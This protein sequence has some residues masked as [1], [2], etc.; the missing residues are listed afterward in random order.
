MESN[1]PLN[2]LFA[3][4]SPARDD[5]QQT[6]FGYDV[7]PRYICNNWDEVNAAQGIGA[8]PFDVIVVGAGMFGGYTAEK[9]YRA[10]SGAA[11]R[12][13]LIDAGA[14]LLQSHIQNL[15][16]QLG[17]SV[18]GPSYLRTRDDASGAQNVVW[19][20]PWIS[21]EAFPGLAYCIGG[22]S[23]FWGG[24]SPELTAADLS[25]WPQNVATYLNSA[26]GYAS[27]E[28][29]IGS[30]VT[31]DFIRQTAL[32]NALLNGI[33]AALPLSGVTEAGEAPL[34]VA[35]SAPQSGLF[36]FDKFSSA[37]FIMD[38]VRNDVGANGA[39][40]DTRRRLFLLPRAQVHRLN[41]SGNRVTA[42]DL[43]VAGVR[44]Q[45]AVAPGANVI[46]ANGTIE[47]TRLA[48]ESLG[49]GSR[50]FG[51]PRVGNLMAHL[52]SNITVRIKRTALGLGSPVGLETVALLAR[53]T[54]AGRRFH[55]Q[56]TAADVAGSNPE[57]MMWSMV[58][59]IDVLGGLLANEDSNWVSITFR[60]IGEM[61]NVA[62]VDGLDPARSWVDLSPET[63]RWGMRRAY[64][65][66]VAT[67]NDR[68]LWQAMDQ[69]AFDLA[70]KLA[71]GNSANIQYWNARASR[72]DDAVPQPDATGGGFWRDRLG[73]THHEAGT[74]FM[75]D[76]GNSITDLNGKFHNIE[77]AYVAG[78][79]LFPSLGSA[80]PSLTALSLARKTAHTIIASA[81][82]PAPA[83]FAPLSLVPS[84]W[85]MVRLPN[86]PASMIHYGSVLETS[87][88]YGLYW[89]IKESFSDFILTLQWR[90]S[91]REENS[92]IYIRI[93]APNVANAL[94]A[95]DA[96]GH[97]IQIDQRGY[98]S[99]TGTEGHSLKI[100]GAI[101]DLQ[102]PSAPTQVQ[103]GA[104]NNL[105][106][107]ANGARIRVTLNGVLVNDYQ[108]SR[109]QTGYI[110]LQAHDSLSRTQFR[111]LM[112]RKLD[113]AGS[114]PSA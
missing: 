103:I 80:N 55:F 11:L 64:V 109:Q 62:A 32:F 108:S 50:Q 15:P 23:L 67:Q 56:I 107:E 81:Q 53:G 51:S 70:L 43:S 58:P 27:T 16:Q 65:N 97:E 95:A 18:G 44:R 21:N 59:D 98:D 77:N 68:Q 20:M 17:G 38:A 45:L 71:G 37:P 54:A 93:P 69:A 78:P 89:Y 41:C 66:L 26:S 46:L 8:Y 96:Q 112:I 47:A 113:A 28:A 94:Q 3:G 72:W 48:L 31:T 75:G 52:R 10:G 22:R 90:I 14:F 101:Y 83:G 102:A 6:D 9:L 4:I 42:L 13:L 74:L 84:D 49:I 106:I 61:E 63:D 40:G 105:S 39:A 5:V 87:G 85:Q 7:V 110:A 30:A 76:P 91:R 79:A 88:W 92:G 34:A 24:W 111:N 2:Q 114:V 36:A 25:N 33:R 86:S 73:T 100:T 19:G 1:M 99:V 104:W 12:T 82:M 57:V 60:G 29:E 35:G